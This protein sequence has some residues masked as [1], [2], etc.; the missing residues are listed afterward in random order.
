[1]IPNDT[2]PQKCDHR[3]RPAGLW[4]GKTPDGKRTG[5]QWFKCVN[6][7]ERV[8]SEIQVVQKGGV[9]EKEGFDIYGNP[10]SP[11]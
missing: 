6:C 8:N 11:K 7:G 2:T 5:G 9:L 3:W 1:M 10:I 4:D